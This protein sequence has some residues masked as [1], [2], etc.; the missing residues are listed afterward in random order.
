MSRHPLVTLD[1]TRLPPRRERWTHHPDWPQTRAVLAAFRQGPDLGLAFL[2]ELQRRRLV[3]R[4]DIR[5]EAVLVSAA[6]AVGLELRRMQ[7]DWHD[8]GALIA[9]AH[10]LAP[11][12]LSS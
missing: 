7:R 1:P 9:D 8:E 6:V 5:S 2:R 10:R 4:E 11:A 3:R 12:L